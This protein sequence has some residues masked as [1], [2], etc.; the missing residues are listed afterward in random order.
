M[1]KF[2]AFAWLTIILGVCSLAWIKGPRFESSIMALLPQSEQSPHSADA[3]RSQ[4]DAMGQLLTLI[5]QHKDEQQAHQATEAIRDIFSE[6]DI[7]LEQSASKLQAQPLAATY[8]FSALSDRT[9]QRLEQGHFDE[10]LH[11]ALGQLFNPVA[12]APVD[13]VADPFGLYGSYLQETNVISQVKVQQGLLRLTTP[14]EPAFALF[15]RLSQNAFSLSTQSQLAPLLNR[16]RKYAETNQIT[17]K[18]SGLVI[19]ASHGAKQAKHEIST[20]GIGSLI[21]IVLLILVSFRR[22]KPLFY[23]LLPVSI[24]AMVALAVTT[25]IFPSVHLI[26]FAF[27]AG[28]VGVA[29]DYSMHY[30]CAQSG[31]TANRLSKAL[32]VGLF[33][34]LISSVLAYAGLALTPFPGLRQIAV[35]SSLGLIASWITVIVWLPLA[36]DLTRMPLHTQILSTC[37][38]LTPT[39]SHQRRKFATL[40]TIGVATLGA[41]IIYSTSANDGLDAL[42]TSPV[43]LLSEDRTVQQAIGNSYQSAFLL[44]SADNLEELLQ[45]EEQTRLTLD[46]LQ[47]QGELGHY[48]SVTQSLPSQAQQQRNL[49]LVAELYQAQLATMMTQIGAASPLVEQAQQ[50]FQQNQ[51]LLTRDMWQTSPLGQVLNSQI[52][53]HENGEL[54]SIIRLSGALS[55]HAKEQL[56]QLNT[57]LDFVE[58]VDPIADISDTLERY[59]MQL[60]SCLIIAYLVV[61]GLLLI[62]YRQQLWLVIL[63]P[64]SA[65]IIAFAFAI[66]VNG[67]YNLFNIVALMLVFGIGLDMGIF[68]KESR[69]AA[70]TWLAVSLSTFTSLLAFG[71]LILSATPVLYHFGVIVLP[72]LLFVWL[73]TPFIQPI[74]YGENRNA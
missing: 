10:Q 9:R 8:R 2:A 33:L 62:R 59:R 38:F 61:S 19:H 21:G 63:P 17:L 31:Q 12:S 68:I 25:L 65:S 5:V 58:F 7:L 51:T 66:L 42:Q 6:S 3:V 40:G 11:Y 36:H 32:L 35:F 34:G 28:L 41:Y 47:Q 4:S 72:G 70:H 54:S 69:G 14:S 73:L 49:T 64:L 50:F 74:S 27:G 57:T 37:Q 53:E 55:T 20:I 44:V 67:G 13:L 56:T 26:T 52:I 23:I 16:V 18:M 43:A 1:R 71:L 39:Y 29:V 30:V 22:L 48:Q 45:R 60:T 46:L 15:Y 24:G